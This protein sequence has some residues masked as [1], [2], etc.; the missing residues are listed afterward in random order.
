MPLVSMVLAVCAATFLSD[1]HFFQLGLL[2][3]LFHFALPTLLFSP[4]GFLVT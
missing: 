1:K 2:R 3:S 4:V